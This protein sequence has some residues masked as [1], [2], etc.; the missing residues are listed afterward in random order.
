MST[1][2]Q[3]PVVRRRRNPQSPHT[4]PKPHQQQI[5]TQPP[6]APRHGSPVP[7]SQ[8]AD[9][10]ALYGQSADIRDLAA[11]RFYEY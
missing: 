5:A 1:P 6:I 7:P 8:T 10:I 3:T 9:E 2:I 11:I 4:E